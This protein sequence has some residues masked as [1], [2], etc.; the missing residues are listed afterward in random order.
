MLCELHVKQT[1]QIVE[2]VL[3]EIQ[4]KQTCRNFVLFLTNIKLTGNLKKGVSV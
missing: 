4:A 2:Y 1:S 3:Y